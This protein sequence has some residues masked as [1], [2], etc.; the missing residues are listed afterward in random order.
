MS[1]PSSNSP[2]GLKQETIEL[3]QSTLSSTEHI[4]SALIYGSRAKETYREGS[5]IDLT[6]IGTPHGIA[7]PARFELANVTCHQA[8][9]VGEGI[10]SADKMFNHRGQ[11]KCTTGISPGKVLYG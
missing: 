9:K 4:E 10:R 6:L 1:N 3:I 11:I 2:F 5:D 8:V 7:D